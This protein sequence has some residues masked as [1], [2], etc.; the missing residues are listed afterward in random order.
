MPIKNSKSIVVA[1]FDNPNLD[2]PE[3][4][5]A[6]DGVSGKIYRPNLDQNNGMWFLM[7]TWLAPDDDDYVTIEW[8][9]EGIDNWTE[10]WTIHFPVMITDPTVER[11]I[12]M[13][14]LNHG[15]FAFRYKVKNGL[16]GVYTDFSEEST[17]DIDLYAPFKAPGSSVKPPIVV[18][19][20]F[21]A[22]P[23]DVITQAVIDANPD[24]TFEVLPYA[25]W[26][27]G[28]TVQ[29]WL[30][31][32]NP[33]DNGPPLN[34][35]PIP[36]GGLEID[37]PNNFFADPDVMDGILF[38]VYRLIDA[39]GNVSELSRTQGRVLK[40]S[41]GLILNPLIIRDPTPDGL[42]DIP[43]WQTHVVVSIPS[44]AYQPGD[45]YTIHWGSQSYGPFALTGVFDFDITLPDQL[46][47][48]EFGTSTV[49][50]TTSATYEI[51]RAGGSDSPAT[52]TEIDVNLWAPGPTPPTPGEENPDLLEIHL[53][54][55]ASDP[56]QD[57]LVKAD[58]DDAAPIVAH[59]TLWMTP[60]PRG[61][62]IIRVY[63][64]STS[65][66]VGTHPL[67]TEAPG[68][69]IEIDLDKT[70]M[71]TLGNGFKDL[72]YTVSEPGSMNANLSGSTPVEVDD[73]IEHVMD[74]AVFL[75]KEPWSQDP[76]GR[77]NCTSVRGGP[78]LPWADR[79]LEVQ[80]LPN[81]D[82]FADGVDVLVEFHGSIG[83]AGA[84]PAIAGT[85]GSTTITL[86]ANTAANGFIFKYGPYV[87]FL[88]PIEGYATPFAS[89]WV[90]YSINLGGTWARSVPAVI[91]VRMFSSNNTCDTSGLP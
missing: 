65:L 73:A 66:L 18:F 13:S 41:S 42:I 12:P 4:P 8:S 48:D 36:V 63:W 43:D 19:P 44:Y 28:D 24:F 33:A 50:V 22:T 53:V 59:I 46:I 56:T 17:A 11:L 38:F 40:R 27:A 82:Y 55:P 34:S 86:D 1:G 54:G 29:W 84:L 45:Q 80:I 91:P 14:V 21:L 31:Q 88:K 83:L 60:S 35:A 58:F 37:V 64:G 32:D 16:G 57:Y 89:S 23:A 77:L 85:T 61:N 9:P 49:T 87:P 7:H 76:R 47:L 81:T 51:H 62:D 39:A 52:A 68:D 74:A 2:P 69:D 6:L 25:D 70:A 26:E 15:K 3:F 72:F 5:D 10:L 90:R 75:N 30:T 20:P 79:H 67:S 78:A 71:A